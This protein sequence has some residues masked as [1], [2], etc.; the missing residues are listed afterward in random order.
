M[1]THCDACGSTVGRLTKVSRHTLCEECRY[2]YMLSMNHKISSE[3]PQGR[4]R[5]DKAL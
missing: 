5:E 3:Y 4:K 2:E 1:G